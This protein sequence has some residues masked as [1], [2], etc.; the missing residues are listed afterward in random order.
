VQKHKVSPAP[1]FF[2]GLGNPFATGRVAMQTGITAG[3]G[4]LRKITAFKWEIAMFPRGRTSRA[5]Y[6][7]SDGLVLSQGGKDHDAAWDLVR[8]LIGEEPGLEIYNAWG[9]I[10]VLKSLA[11]ADEFLKVRPGDIRVALESEPFMHPGDFNA[12]Y[13][14][15]HTALRNE[16]TAAVLN[17]KTAQ[18]AVNDATRAVQAIIDK[19]A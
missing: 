9:G 17:K 1:G 2:E 18:E 6:G 8:W 4:S 19:N 15:W 12:G 14:E 3:M 13:N 16:L 11:F 10:P 7:G 5:I